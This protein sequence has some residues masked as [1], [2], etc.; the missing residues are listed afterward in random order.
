[1]FKI[2]SLPFIIHHFEISYFEGAQLLFYVYDS[3]YSFKNN[4][5]VGTFVFFGDVHLVDYH[6]FTTVLV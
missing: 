4:L 2:L 5:F 3:Q 6:L 1:M